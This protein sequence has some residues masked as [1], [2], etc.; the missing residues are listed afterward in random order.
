MRDDTQA[1]G[2]TRKLTHKSMTLTPITHIRPAKLTRNEFN[3]ICAEFTIDPAIALECEA[4]IKA[5][6]TGSPDA[7]RLALACEF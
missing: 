5:L 4:V 3:A 6:K 2:I 7:L 1:T